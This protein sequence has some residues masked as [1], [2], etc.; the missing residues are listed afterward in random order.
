MLGSHYTISLSPANTRSLA[1]KL[2]PL[3]NVTKVTL[4]HA[5][6]FSPSVQEFS[7]R[8]EIM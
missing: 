4:P 8:K 3:V 2:L 6:S 5:A 7:S 1:V